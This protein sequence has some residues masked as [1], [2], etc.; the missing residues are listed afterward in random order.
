MSNEAESS[1]YNQNQRA[2]MMDNKGYDTANVIQIRLNT[3]PVIRQLEIYLKGYAEVI[4]I[5]N[6]GN[7]RASLTQ[8][9]EPLANSKGIQAIMSFFELV[10]NPQS[11]QGNFPTYDEYAQFLERTRKDLATDLIINLN[12]YGINRKSYNAIMSRLMRIVETFSSRL[13]GNKERE[14]Y[15]NTIRTSETNSTQMGNKKGILPW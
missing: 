11:V 8:I 10:F 9:G 12:H 5:D 15:V 14:S 4:T 1:D 3:D 13:I 7:E 6:Q 2:Y